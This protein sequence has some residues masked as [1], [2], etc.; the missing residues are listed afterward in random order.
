MDLHLIIHSVPIARTRTTEANMVV[1]FDA[2]SGM[3]RLEGAGTGAEGNDLLGEIY[4]KNMTLSLSEL[5][6]ANKLVKFT[7]ID[8]TNLLNLTGN[9]VYRTREKFESRRNTIVRLVTLLTH[10]FVRKYNDE[11]REREKSKDKK[12]TA[13]AEPTSTEVSAGPG[14]VVATDVSTGAGKRLHLPRDVLANDR[15]RERFGYIHEYLAEIEAAAQ[16][17]WNPCVRNAAVFAFLSIKDKNKAKDFLL[18]MRH[19]LSDE[20]L[21]LDDVVGYAN[22]YDS[23]TM[24]KLKHLR[25]H[26]LAE[27]D[28]ANITAEAMDKV[29]ARIMCGTAILTH[30]THFAVFGFEFDHLSYMDYYTSLSK[31][32]SKGHFN[33]NSTAIRPVV[34]AYIAMFVPKIN[35]AHE[36]NVNLQKMVV[37]HD[38]A[39][40]EL[41][42]RIKNYLKISKTRAGTGGAKRKLRG[43]NVDDFVPDPEVVYDVFRSPRP[44][45][46]DIRR[47]TR[48]H[49]GSKF[50]TEQLGSCQF[51]CMAYSKPNADGSEI[52]VNL[53]DRPWHERLSL[54]ETAFDTKI[55]LY[56]L[57]G[58]ELAEIENEYLAVEG[59]ESFVDEDGLM[60]QRLVKRFLR[61]PVAASFGSTSEGK[62]ARKLRKNAAAKSDEYIDTPEESEDYEQHHLSETHL[63]LEPESTE[64]MDIV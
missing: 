18:M 10:L 7:E 16:P 36:L 51:D 59:L 43:T 54:S 21:S 6:Y 64:N 1:D 47:D 12:S 4:H 24:D 35:A 57:T 15:I 17:E 22:L 42:S 13:T 25:V 28:V 38:N 46:D 11:I 31:K 26:G 30:M 37:A 63:G 9:L 19:I 32:S 56:Q 53:M 40:P 29:I 49:R 61:K 8:I 14:E 60:R 48:D 3:T 5:P 50:Y 20:M 52:V 45:A 34:E 2:Q 23:A 44:F 39:V 62:R 41:I 55:P 27:L 33:G 58:A